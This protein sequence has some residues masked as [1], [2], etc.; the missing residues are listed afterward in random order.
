[1]PV[2]KAVDAIENYNNL[3]NADNLL[4]L[5]MIRTCFRDFL[6]TYCSIQS[7]THRVLKRLSF[8]FNLYSVVAKTMNKRCSSHLGRHPFLESV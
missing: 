5:Q 2:G 6:S 8:L 4:T 7:A 3:N 1:M